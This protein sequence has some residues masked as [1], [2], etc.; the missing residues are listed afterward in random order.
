M[1]FLYEHETLAN[2][3]FLLVNL[4]LLAVN[5]IAFKTTPTEEVKSDYPAK[6]TDVLTLDTNGNMFTDHKQ[7]IN[8][9]RYLYRDLPQLHH[10][11]I[12]TT[13]AKLN[14]GPSWYRVMLNTMTSPLCYLG[15]NYYVVYDTLSDA[16]VLLFSRFEKN[17]TVVLEF[18]KPETPKDMSPEATVYRIVRNELANQDF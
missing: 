15:F 13:K 16:G 1:Q 12:P 4:G 9:L 8:Y 2:I 17:F 7:V 18:Y 5:Y 14:M 3:I 6:G 10:E 11:D